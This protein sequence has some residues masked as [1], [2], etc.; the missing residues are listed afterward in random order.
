MKSLVQ[1][2]VSNRQFLT[3]LLGVLEKAEA[4]CAANKLDPGAYLNARLFEDMQPFTFQV[5]QSIN[6]SVGALAQIRGQIQREV[7]RLVAG[8]T[9]VWFG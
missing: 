8:R 7:D 2:S 5:M 3:S 6:H 9:S 1:Q 4:Y